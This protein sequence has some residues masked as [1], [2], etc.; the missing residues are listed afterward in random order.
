MTTGAPTG[1]PL[2]PGSLGLPLI[3]ETLAL[4]SNPFGFLTERGRRHGPIFKSRVVGQRVVFLSGLEGARAFYD[5][6]NVSRANAHPFPVLDLFGGA[7]TQMLDGD[8]HRAL[9]TMAS[10]SFDHAAIARYLPEL[11]P[12]IE[13]ALARLAAADRPARMTDELRKL[14]IEIICQNVLGLA[15]GAETDAFSADYGRV[16]AGMV[17]LPVALPG[18][19]FARARA[20]RDR[21]LGRLRAVIAERRARPRQDGLSRLLGA[22]AP[23]GHVFSDDEAALEVHHVF[24]AGFI[25]YALLSEVVRRLGEDASLRA[26]CEDEVRAHAAAWP[27]TLESLATLRTSMNV[28]LEAKRHVPIVPFVFGRA[29][30][31]FTC[32]GFEVP[33]GWHVYLALGLS[34]RDPSIYRDPEAF[35]PDRFGPER[36]E[37]RKPGA[38]APYG[39]GPHTCLGAGLAEVQVT[40]LV[41]TLLRTVELRIDPPGYVLKKINSPGPTPNKHFGMTLVRVRHSSR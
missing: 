22:Q 15:P 24:I 11:Q 26:R 30:R 4:I 40:L 13:A 14:A 10:A 7:N 33:E 36:A 12:L 38:Y 1:T 41:A 25:V 39:L 23:D 2:P 17:A 21:V 18:S 20:A 27:L 5:A 9:K 3:G 37:H 31:T 19:T 16:L 32:G 29:R 28:V 35:D 6:E 8:R 34:N